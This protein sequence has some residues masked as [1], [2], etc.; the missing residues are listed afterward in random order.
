MRVDPSM[1]EDVR[2]SWIHSCGRVPDS[3]HPSI[4]CSASRIVPARKL[5][6]TVR[7]RTLKPMADAC[8]T[9]LCVGARTV[10]GA[11]WRAGSSF[12]FL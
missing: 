10:S 9:L 4:A 8:D 5:A 7:G 12:I 2:S 11:L 3:T 1:L 6:S